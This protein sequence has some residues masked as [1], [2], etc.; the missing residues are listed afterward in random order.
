M[1]HLLSAKYY[2]FASKLSLLCF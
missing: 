1:T 2:I